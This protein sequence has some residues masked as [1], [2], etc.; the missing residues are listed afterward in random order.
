MLTTRL[1]QRNEVLWF[2]IKCTCFN[3]D[4]KLFKQVTVNHVDCKHGK[5]QVSV[6]DLR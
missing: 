5:T 1:F 6:I 3:D 2:F 4:L